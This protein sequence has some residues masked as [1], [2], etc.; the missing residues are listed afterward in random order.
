MRLFEG[1]EA[2]GQFKGMPTLFIS[3]DVPIVQI[4]KYLT[5]HHKQVYFGADGCTVVNWDNV[6]QLLSITNHI[7][8]AEVR[9]PVPPNVVQMPMFFCVV[10]LQ[11]AEEQFRG[12]PTQR[13]LNRIMQSVVEMEERVQIKFDTDVC[14]CMFPLTGVLINE[15]V[16]ILNDIELWKG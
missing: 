5:N 4:K 7:V 6:Y 12:I 3:G 2:E 15:Q 16:D 14:T 1:N 11:F 9:V 10:N 8:T 13:A